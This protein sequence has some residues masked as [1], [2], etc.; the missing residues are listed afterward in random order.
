MRVIGVIDLA[1]GRAVHARAGERAAYRPVESPLLSGPGDAVA[2]ATVYRERLALQELY[3]ADLDALGGRSPQSALI[4]SIVDVGV[5]VLADVGAAS[6]ADARRAIEYGAARVI[7]ALETLPSLDAL[8]AVVEAVGGERVIFS[9][10]L[11]SG[12]PVV[13]HAAAA[14]IRAGSPLELV[15]VAAKC[16]VAGT[17]ILDLARVGTGTGV[18]GELIRAIRVAHPTLELLAG[19]GV[20]DRADLDRLARCGCD[21]ALVATALLEG[22]ITRADVEAVERASWRPESQRSDSR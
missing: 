3:V 6:P 2:L 13:S 11:R 16:G 10:D 8:E 4:R 17:I 19:G 14:V 21:G 12:V 7:V 1:G 22:R 15:G 18:D 20:R 9:L 5:P